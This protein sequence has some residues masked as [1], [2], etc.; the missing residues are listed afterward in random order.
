MDQDGPVAALLAAGSFFVLKFKEAA[1][2]L[3][4]DDDEPP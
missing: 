4:C 1:N 3:G 2:E